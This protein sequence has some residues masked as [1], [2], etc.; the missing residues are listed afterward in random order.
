MLPGSVVAG[1]LALL[2]VLFFAVRSAW[3]SR[4]LPRDHSAAGLPAALLALGYAGLA[5]FALLTIAYPALFVLGWLDLLTHSVLQLR[6]PG[7][8]AVQLAGTGLVA[9]GLVLV[10]WSLH[11]I[12]PGA[13]TAK[14]PYARMR[15]PMYTG[16]V[17]VFAGLF[18]LTLNLIALLPLLAIPGQIAVARREEITLETRYGAA[19][20]AYAAR[21]GRF[22]PG[23]RRRG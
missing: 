17:F 1:I 3:D 21:T 16:Y 22:L 10:F 18:P 13:L 14:G 20:R 12:D 19:Y 4:K 6:F 23:V 15:H 2:A 5:A 11:A 7:D 9:L 8:T